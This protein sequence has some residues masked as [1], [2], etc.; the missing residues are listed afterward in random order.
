MTYRMRGI[1]LPGW[2]SQTGLATNKV[3]LEYMRRE[4]RMERVKVEYEISA[5]YALAG[6]PDASAE[7]RFAV[8]DPPKQAYFAHLNGTVHQT[9]YK[10]RMLEKKMVELLERKAQMNRIDWI[11]SPDFNMADWF[12]GK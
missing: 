11:N 4:R 10:R 9:A 12:A 5:A 1:L 8:V 7:D 3:W 2:T 6:S